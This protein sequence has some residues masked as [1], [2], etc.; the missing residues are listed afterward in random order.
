MYR[1][2]AAKQAGAPKHE[3]ANLRNRHVAAT[4]CCAARF[5][6]LCSKTCSFVSA[7]ATSL[8]GLPFPALARKP[9]IGSRRRK[10]KRVYVC[11]SR[12]SP[13][14]GLHQGSREEPESEN[15]STGERLTFGRFGP[16]VFRSAYHVVP[17]EKTITSY[18][19]EN[20]AN[21]RMWPTSGEG[22]ETSRQTRRSKVQR[23]R[24]YYFVG[25]HVCMSVCVYICMSFCYYD[26]TKECTFTRLFSR[27]NSTS[28]LEI[29]SSCKV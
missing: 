12:D 20:T 17:C 13:T 6:T 27:Q 11:Q 5:A 2:C 7:V 19:T 24:L 21:K 10:D 14:I 4:Y 26:E 22:R 25:L 29:F 3:T 23:H 1:C 28:L 8:P 15:I 16:T 18:A 9:Y